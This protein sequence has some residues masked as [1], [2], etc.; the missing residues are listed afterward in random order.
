MDQ[1][2]TEISNLN[3]K[4]DAIEQLL[5]KDYEEWTQK[6]SLRERMY[7]L[8]LL[9]SG[10]L[11]SCC[12][13]LLA[14]VSKKDLNGGACSALWLAILSSSG[15]RGSVCGLSC[16]ASC[17][18]GRRFCCVKV[19]RSKAIGN[20]YEYGYCYDRVFRSIAVN[21]SYPGC[22]NKTWNFQTLILFNSKLGFRRGSEGSRTF[23]QLDFHTQLKAPTR[24]PNSVRRERV[25][26]DK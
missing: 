24:V 7:T 6:P 14:R 23:V 15:R 9:W 10:L 16:W 25:A 17:N 2:A 11:V 21:L 4:I 13:S 19:P 12:L 8:L 20:A 3:L 1:I 26:L 22:L 5:D 18:C